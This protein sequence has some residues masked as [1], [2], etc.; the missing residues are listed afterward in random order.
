MRLLIDFPIPFET[1]VAGRYIVI[2]SK[3]ILLLIANH[4]HHL[5]GGSPSRAKNQ[6]SRFV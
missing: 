5:Q 2:I 4:F 3:I 1:F 6:T